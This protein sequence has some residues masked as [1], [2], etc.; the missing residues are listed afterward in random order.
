MR[1]NDLIKI[2]IILS[3]WALLL[4]VLL[5]IACSKEYNSQDAMIELHKYEINASAKNT[6]DDY[7]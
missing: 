7:E 4:F 1:A 6:G 5:P 2:S 3:V